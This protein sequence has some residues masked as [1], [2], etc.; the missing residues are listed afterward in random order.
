MQPTQQLVGAA[1]ASL[2]SMGGTSRAKPLHDGPYVGDHSGR[3][4]AALSGPWPGICGWGHG[5]W[6]SPTAPC[7][8]PARARW[9]QR[10][11]ASLR[12]ADLFLCAADRRTLF[13][14]SVPQPA[15]VSFTNRVDAN[16]SRAATVPSRSAQLWE[17]PGSGRVWMTVPGTRL[18]LGDAL[19]G[20]TEVP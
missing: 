14:P 4:G 12:P 16:Q 13:T 8:W 11:T 17:G 10:W 7:G 20:S 19:H 5:P 2:G 18:V 1:P 3:V 15:P 6:P 9:S